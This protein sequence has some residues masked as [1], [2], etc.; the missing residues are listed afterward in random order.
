MILRAFF[1]FSVALWLAY[2]IIS[3]W[4]RDATAPG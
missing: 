4:Q 1:V 2:V 3:Q